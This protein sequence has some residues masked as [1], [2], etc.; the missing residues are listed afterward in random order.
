MHHYC[1]IKKKIKKIT[2]KRRKQNKTKNGEN[3]RLACFNS[4]RYPNFSLVS[5][6]EQSCSWGGKYEVN[7]ISWW[8]VV[9]Y[10]GTESHWE[11]LSL[12]SLTQKSHIEGIYKMSAQRPKRKTNH[13][14]LTRK[15]DFIIVD[16]NLLLWHSGPGAEV[17]VAVQPQQVTAGLYGSHASLHLHTVFT[18]HPLYLYWIRAHAA[19]I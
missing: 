9:C 14:T 12:I 4:E 1:V 2:I 17:Q 6:L 13:R 16:W 18:A 5:K 3:E 19:C 8:T 11:L 10:S 15:K 7:I